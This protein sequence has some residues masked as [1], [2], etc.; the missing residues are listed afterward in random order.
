MICVAIWVGVCIL[1]CCNIDTL[2]GI[3]QSQEETEILQRNREFIH[4]NAREISEAFERGNTHFSVVESVKLG[5][6]QMESNLNRMAAEYEL[7]ELRLEANPDD[8]DGESLPLHFMFEGS[9][10]KTIRM[11]TA[12]AGDFPFILIQKVSM[13]IDELREMVSCQVSL[14]YRYRVIE[15]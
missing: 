15:Q 1:A 14:I 8:A 11:L 13:S 3:A 10:M 5:I 2:R 9:V 12:L 7:Q 6:L 4:T